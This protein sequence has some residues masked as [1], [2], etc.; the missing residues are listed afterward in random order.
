MDENSIKRVMPY[1][2]DAEKAVLGSM[3][4]DKEAVSLAVDML[5]SDDFYIREYGILFQAMADLFVKGKPA[6]L[7]EIQE[8]LKQNGAPAEVAGIDV[9]QEIMSLMPTSVN[10]KHYAEIV[11]NKSILR[12]LIKTSQEIENECYEGKDDMDGILY[13]AEKNILKVTQQG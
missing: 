9:I 5:K 1:S 7:V 6:E 10:I 11:K 2:R 3:L 13:E 4:M 8:Q 12:Q